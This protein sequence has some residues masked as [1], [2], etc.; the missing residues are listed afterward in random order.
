[1]LPRETEAPDPV[2]VGQKTSVVTLSGKIIDLL[3]DLAELDI[4][5]VAVGLSRIKRFNNQISEPISVARHSL[6]VRRLLLHEPLHVQKLALLH[7]AHEMLSAD[8]P[9]P[10]KAAV[11]LFGSAWDAF[12]TR[13]QLSVYHRFNLDYDHHSEG[14]VHAADLSVRQW[15][16]YSGMAECQVPAFR[17]LGCL[18]GDTYSAW[19]PSRTEEED[20]EDFLEAWTKVTEPQAVK[21]GKMYIDTTL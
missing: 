12:E 17:A 9:S 16:L 1:M 20:A 19:F 18:A 2:Y 14:L 13:L 10:V 15:E 3:G 11:R 21:R 4:E 6:L 7:D 8:I 5:D